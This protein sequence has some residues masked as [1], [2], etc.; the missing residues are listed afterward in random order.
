MALDAHL[1]TAVAPEELRAA[2]LLLAVDRVTLARLRDACPG[3]VPRAGLL[4]RSA[5]EEDA[6]VP[7]PAAPR[8]RRRARLRAQAARPGRAHRARLV[9]AE[10]C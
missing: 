5:S 3:A 7:D 2:D 6:G 10:G 9:G 8:A 1:P 4:R